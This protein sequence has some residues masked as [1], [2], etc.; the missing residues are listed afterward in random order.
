VA[1][2]EKLLTALLWAHVKATRFINDPANHEKVVQYAMEFTGKDKEVVEEALK[3]IK[4]VEYPDEK[5]FRKY[6]ERLKESGFLQNSIKDLGYASEDGFFKD[7]LMRNAYDYVVEKLREDPSWIP[8]APDREINMGHLTADLHEL[9]WYVALKEGYFQQAGIKGNLEKQY[10]NGPAV[11]EAF[12]S[13]ELDVS[14]L[15]GAPATLKRI[16]DDIRIHIVAGANNEGSAIVVKKGSEIKT[17]EDLK[18][19][20]IAIPGFGTVQ[21]FI[22]RM[23]LEEHNL[24][25]RLKD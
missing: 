6:Y 12:K 24:E 7:F 17:I 18:G 15:G 14:Y 21:D 13:G 20:T 3:H 5:E 11:M 19:R 8:D 2:D 25:V 1:K 10:A 16:N 23:A 9:A 4:F 22:L